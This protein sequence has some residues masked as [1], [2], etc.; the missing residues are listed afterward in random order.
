MLAS[1]LKCGRWFYWLWRRKF[2]AAIGLFEN[3]R[4]SCTIFGGFWALQNW[5]SNNWAKIFQNQLR[6]LVIWVSQV[7]LLIELW[8]CAFWK[9]STSFCRIDDAQTRAC[10]NVYVSI[11]MFVPVEKFIDMIPILIHI[12][13]HLCFGAKQAV[14]QCCVYFSQRHVKD[15]VG[16]ACKCIGHCWVSIPI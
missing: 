1:C 3:D 6:R 13:D 12:Y 8:K 11:H 7:L 10:K 4:L 5:N 15:D 16:H 2:E 9:S 14:L